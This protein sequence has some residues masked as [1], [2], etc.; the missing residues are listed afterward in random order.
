MHRLLSI[1][2]LLTILF[3]IVGPAFALGQ[4]SS[5]NLPACCRR[6]GQHHCAMSMAERQA[7][8]DAAAKTPTWKTPLE[9]CPY[10]PSPAVP[11]ATHNNLLVMPSMQISIAWN[12][13]GEHS[14]A[15]TERRRAVAR[16]RARG[17]RGPPAIQ[18][19]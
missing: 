5:T 2:M 11:S 12:V 13:I 7:F 6:N 4:E 14:V 15:Q 3:P 10:C 16:E 17:K 1:V 9:R 18:L 8:A 19:S